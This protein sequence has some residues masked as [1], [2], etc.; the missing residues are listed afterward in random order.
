MTA[1][2]GRRV[3]ST[4]RIL[5]ESKASGARLLGRNVARS[6][7]LKTRT[8]APNSIAGSG[9]LQVFDS[10]SI[11]FLVGVQC[12]LID[13]PMHQI[14]YLPALL[15]IALIA[16]GCESIRTG[17]PTATPVSAA[18]YG[19]G[20]GA[21]L[22]LMTALTARFTAL[23][24]EVR[25]TIEDV[26]QDTAVASVA[27]GKADFGFI[28]RDLK[29]GEMD[30]VRSIPF[31][32]TGTGLGVNPANPLLG[33]SKDQIRRIYSGEITNWAQLGGSPGEIRPFIRETGSATRAS[34]ESYFFDGTP[35]YGQNVVE[36]TN[37]APMIQAIRD[38]RTAV[39]MITV[40]SRRSRT[41]Q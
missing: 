24:P 8:A 11:R 29:P 37:S 32:A 22:D 41:L 28:S 12:R 5:R 30:R 10:S 35:V 38:I 34:F 15:V 16:T 13:N 18:F 33:L 6:G 31:A 20:T 36:I 7:P 26:G 9:R 4:H 1:E 19:A 21:G 27:I 2:N 14:R 39:G 25:F 23:H 17:Q 40:Q 3:V